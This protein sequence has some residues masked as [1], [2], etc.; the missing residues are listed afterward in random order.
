MG[1]AISGVTYYFMNVIQSNRIK[2]YAV[3]KKK[4]KRKQ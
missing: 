2:S 1:P 3:Y 4:K